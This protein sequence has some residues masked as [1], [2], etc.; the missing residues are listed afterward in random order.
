MKV[1]PENEP[2]KS[3]FIVGG[4]VEIDCPA[5]VNVTT[6]FGAKPVPD[7]VA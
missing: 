6:E 2:F 1:A 7:I 4:E 5:N 3:V